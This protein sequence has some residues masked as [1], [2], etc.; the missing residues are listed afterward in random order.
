MYATWFD[1]NSWLLELAGVRI[2]VDPWLVDTLVFAN[3]PWFFEGARP[4]SH[5]IPEAIDLIL[6][7]QGLADHAHPATLEVLDRQIPVVASPNAAQVVRAKGYQQ[8]TALAHGETFVLKQQ[9]E[10]TAVPG[11]PIGPFLVENGFVLRDLTSDLTVFYEP[12]GYPDP[13]L[14]QFAPID[15]AIAPTKDLAVPL[16]GSIVRGQQGTYD[17]IEWLQPQVLLPT[18]DAAQV[19]YNGV[20]ASML[21]E[22][23]GVDALQARLDQAGFATKILPLTVGERTQLPVTH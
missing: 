2:L 20:L 12:H 8:V 19:E 14:K 18:T 9:V 7:S 11:A 3:A 4:Y 5:P 1:A 13:Q 16:L 22:T 10:I 15:V 21:K 6:L 23:G 17:L